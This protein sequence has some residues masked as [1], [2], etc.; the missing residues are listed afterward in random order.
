MREDLRSLPAAGPGAVGEAVVEVVSGDP[1]VD[2][3][4]HELVHHGGDG[5]VQ[6]EGDQEQESKEG[7]NRNS[8]CFDRINNKF[9]CL[10]MKENPQYSMY[11]FFG[12]TFMKSMNFFSVIV[13]PE[14]TITMIEG[15]RNKVIHRPRK[16]DV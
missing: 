8:P 13:V 11:V 10:I 15:F 6:H 5:G 1:A 14:S 2:W 12:R 9:T 3:S 4:L 7:D 16:R